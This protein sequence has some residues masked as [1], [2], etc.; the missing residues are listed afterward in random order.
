MLS[1]ALLAHMLDRADY[2]T[3][4]VDH[5]NQPSQ[6]YSSFNDTVSS[7]VSGWSCDGQVFVLRDC[8]RSD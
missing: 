8:S 3:S 4:D 1:P 6:V 5:D 2:Q 7:Y